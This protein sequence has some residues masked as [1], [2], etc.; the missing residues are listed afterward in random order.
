MKPHCVLDCSAAMAWLFADERDTWSDA[1]LDGVA[2]EGAV[3]PQL[4]LHE[5]ANVL[6]VATRRSRLTRAEATHAAELLRSLPLTIRSLGPDDLPA[7]LE[8]ALDCGLSAYDATY[9]LT[10]A[11]EGLA[12]ATKDEKLQGAARRRGI[13]VV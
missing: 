6:A 9:L 3:V 5:V 8:L 13:P 7:L 1:L 10:A 4:W 11:R 2:R 12:L